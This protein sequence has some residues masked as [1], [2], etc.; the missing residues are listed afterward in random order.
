MAAFQAA[1]AVD[2]RHA[3]AHRLAAIMYGQR[4]DLANEY[5]M[6]STALAESGDPFY[7]DYLYDV[8]RRQGRGRRARRRRPATDSRR[9][10]PATPG[11]AS[12][13]AMSSPCWATRRVP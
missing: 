1:I 5:R 6:I 4:G 12:G 10:S 9:R 2:P 11:S 7:A 8:P 3:E 13:S